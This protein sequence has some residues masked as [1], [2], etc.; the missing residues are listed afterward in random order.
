MPFTTADLIDMIRHS[1]RHFLKH[2]R[3]LRQDQWDWKPYPECKSIRET[4]AHLI[5]VDRAALVSLETGGEPDYAAL[6]E[7]ARDLDRLHA[8]MGDSHERLCRHLNTHYAGAP[9][10]TEVCLYGDRQTLGRAL[11]Y[12]PSED[13]YH[14]GQVAFIRIA[15]DPGWDY[16]SSIY[17]SE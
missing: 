4:L 12:F 16:Y 17:G 14:A 9:L 10:D 1:R 5:W 13:Y 7:P 6:E 3:G 8:L 2:L 11:A 15:T